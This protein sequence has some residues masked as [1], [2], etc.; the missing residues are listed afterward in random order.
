MKVNINAS[1]ETEEK[2][3]DLISLVLDFSLEDVTLNINY[4]PELT[5]ETI[6]KNVSE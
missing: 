3:K 5:S 1:V 2:L 6:L 4:L